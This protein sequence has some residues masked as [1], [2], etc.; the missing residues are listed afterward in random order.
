[1]PSETL[2]TAQERDS[3]RTRFV[4][5]KAKVLFCHLSFVM[6][7]IVKLKETLKIGSTKGS[8]TSLP[9]RPESVVCFLM[10]DR[11]YSGLRSTRHVPVNL[12]DP[13]QG[14]FGHM[15]ASKDKSFICRSK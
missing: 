15:N 3:P 9:K 6:I 12:D 10:F 5:A 14:V 2:H 1:M 8:N 11:I 7:G 13:Q 4:K